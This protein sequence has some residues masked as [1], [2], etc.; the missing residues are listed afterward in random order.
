MGGSAGPR[1]GPG[2][3]EKIKEH[4]AHGASGE[5]SFFFFAG[6]N[7]T[8]SIQGLASASR[9]NVDGSGCFAPTSQLDLLGSSR[10]WTDPRL[11]QQRRQGLGIDI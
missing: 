7:C 2:E 5:F 6:A 3:W 11:C 10:A 9:L 1:D 8:P 4:G